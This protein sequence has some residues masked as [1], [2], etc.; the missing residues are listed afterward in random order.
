MDEYGINQK[1]FYRRTLHS[2]LLCSDKQC[3]I[4]HP[5]QSCFEYT[6]GYDTGG[7]PIKKVKCYCESTACRKLSTN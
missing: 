4:C 1:E 2:K 6:D 7:N 5:E 3:D